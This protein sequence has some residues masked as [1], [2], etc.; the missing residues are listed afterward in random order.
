MRITFNYLCP[1]C[2][3]YT[4]GAPSCKGTLDRPHRRPIKAIR[5]ATIPTQEMLD[6]ISRARRATGNEHVAAALAE[7]ESQVR[8][9]ERPT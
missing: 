9:A 4:G 8:S 3:R 1:T 7:L 6:A 2:K 5:T